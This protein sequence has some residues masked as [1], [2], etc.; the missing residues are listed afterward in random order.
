MKKNYS[1]I[2]LL[3]ILTLFFIF[4]IFNFHANCLFLKYLH[5]Y[6]PGC[7]LTRSFKAILQLNLKS[8]VQYNILG[9]PLFVF[10]IYSMIRLS[11]DSIRNK[12]QYFHELNY[13]L[14]K[15]YIII[16]IIILENGIYNN[17]K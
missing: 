8:A 7:G 9:I 13:F 1:L 4:F 11:I 17:I 6:C 2:C 14:S 3:C 12:H 16:L 5:I 15:Y 10:M